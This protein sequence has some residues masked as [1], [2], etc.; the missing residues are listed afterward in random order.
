MVIIRAILD[1]RG[2]VGKWGVGELVVALIELDY[3]GKIKSNFLTLHF[4]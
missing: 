1:C 4:L 2:T 3:L